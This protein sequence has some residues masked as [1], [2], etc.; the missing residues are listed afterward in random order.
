MLLDTCAKEKLLSCVNYE[1]IYLHLKS[2]MS[3]FE[4]KSIPTY[5]APS[6]ADRVSIAIKEPKRIAHPNQVPHDILSDEF[7]NQLILSS[8]P[9]N[10]KFEIHKTIWKII[11]IDAKNVILQLPE[12]LIRFGPVLVDVMT[13]Y[14]SKNGHDNV[15]FITMGDLTY[16]A[17]CIDDYLAAS[18]GCDLIVHYA[19]SCL[20]PINKLN[21]KVKYLYIFLDIK[22]DLDHVKKCIEHNFN[23]EEHVIALAGTIQFVSSVHELSSQLKKVGFNIIL[24]QSRPLSS[25]EII[26]C[27]AP[28]LDDRINAIVFICDGRFHLE[29]LMIANPNIKAYRYD[30][31][32]RKL[33]SESYHFDQMVRH[34]GA[35]IDTAIETMRSGG[36]FGFVLGTLG[37]QGS[38]T[39]YHRLIQR[40]LEK[41]DCKCLKLML[42]E[43][44]QTALDPIESVDIWVQIACPRLS[45]D[46]GHFFRKPLLNPYELAKAVSL[47]LSSSNSKELAVEYPMDFYAKDSCGDHTPNHVC[48]NKSECLCIN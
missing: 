17:C 31:Y 41:T 14:L 18:M 39:V 30:P 33:T 22:F 27:T 37:R 12:G 8:L 23:P 9:K 48:Q 47:Y 26:G 21:S 42:P 5:K 35:A 29:A 13:A 36:T 2:K 3:S 34:R 38:E 24:P 7:L 25:A 1:N 6:Q 16:G 43:V 45:I 40:L 20:V 46:W 11:Q 44:V 28:K 4:S 15:R 19:H 10:Y 32:S